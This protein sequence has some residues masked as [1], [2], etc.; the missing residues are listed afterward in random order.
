M[1][2]AEGACV[3]LTGALNAQAKGLATAFQ[4]MSLK[5]VPYWREARFKPAHRRSKP[6][7]P[8]ESLR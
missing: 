4:C 6:V 1:E 5:G 7:S 2:T 8:G 3:T